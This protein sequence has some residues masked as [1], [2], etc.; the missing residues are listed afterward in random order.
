MYTAVLMS[1]KREWCDL[2]ISGDKTI[3][4]RKRAPNIPPPYIVYMY[5]CLPKSGE[6]TERDGKVVAQ[7]VCEDVIP[8]SVP[9]PAY[10]QQADKTL[11]DAACLSYYAAHQ[12]L[13]SRTGCGLKISDVVVYDRP[14]EVQEF[15]RCDVV[16]GL[17][18]RRMITR[19]PHSW[20]YVG[21]PGARLF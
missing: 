1:I 16:D 18:V 9:Y 3:E 19:P 4:F 13:G 12:Y 2:I 15:F 21:V 10:Q 7:F 20:C 17:L 5:Q 6:R 14:K 8:F 11:L